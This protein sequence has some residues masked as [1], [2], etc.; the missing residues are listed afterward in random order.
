METLRDWHDK[1]RARTGMDFAPHALRHSVGSHVTEAAGDVRTAQA[2]LGH[3][4]QRTTEGFYAH[5]VKVNLREKANIFQ[6]APAAPKASPAEA[7]AAPKPMSEEAVAKVASR[8]VVTGFT[9]EKNAEVREAI[10][11]QLKKGG[12]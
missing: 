11:N 3:K 5:R 2:L 6:V 7:T 4:S 12:T 8:F 10:L 1:V 9:P